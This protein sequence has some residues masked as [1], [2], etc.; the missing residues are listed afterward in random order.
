MGLAA[1]LAPAAVAADAPVI[2]VWGDSLSAAYGIPVEQGWAS[3]LQRKLRSAGYPH[4]VVNGS[5]SGETTAGGLARLPGALQKHRPALVLL[6]LGG[7]DGLRGLPVAK[8]RENLSAMT[9]LARASGAKTLLFEMQLPAN[10]GAAYRDAFIAAFPAVARAERV[11]LVP[12]FLQAIALDEG[13]FQADGIHPTVRAQA[14]M[15][16]AVWP[17]LRAE[18]GAAP[19]A[20]STRPSQP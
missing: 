19:A 2:L 15:L 10:Y 4:R 16:E 13:A 18:L 12:F 1:G 9:R 3:L 7:N 17:A 11:P 8:L 14:P 20:A 5:V 6:E